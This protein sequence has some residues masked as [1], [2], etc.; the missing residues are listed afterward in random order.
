MGGKHPTGFFAA[1]SMTGFE[2][3]RD[4]KAL[5]RDYLE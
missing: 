4:L 1:L 5:P 2:S 3:I